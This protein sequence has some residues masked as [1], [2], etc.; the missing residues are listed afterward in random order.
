MYFILQT[1]ERFSK[2]LGTSGWWKVVQE[3]Y[4]NNGYVG[5]INFGGSTFYN[6]TSSSKHP[7]MKWCVTVFSESLRHKFDQF[8]SFA[9]AMP[10]YGNYIDRNGQDQ[11]DVY[12]IARNAINAGALPLDEESG[13]YMVLTAGEV[14]SADLRQACGWHGANV[15]DAGVADDLTIR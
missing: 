2:H 8:T 7:K 1:F 10:R 11:N 12:Y 5:A 6:S 4:G 3:Y 15:A 9:H 13:M 14:N